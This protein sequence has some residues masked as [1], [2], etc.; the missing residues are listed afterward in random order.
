MPEMYDVS[1]NINCKM[2]GSTATLSIDPGD[3][4]GYYNVQIAPEDSLHYIEPGM[5]MTEGAIKSLAN[6]FYISAR[7]AMKGGASAEQ[8][9]TLDVQLQAGKK[10][11]IIVFAVESKDGEVPVLRSMPSLLYI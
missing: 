11:M 8:F 5:Q 1:F 2:S 9:R 4:S 6:K 3:W 10:Y 7:N